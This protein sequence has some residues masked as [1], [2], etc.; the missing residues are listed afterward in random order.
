M[1]KKET[2]TNN[3]KYSVRGAEINGSS[4]GN[5]DVRNGGGVNSPK[6]KEG[7]IKVV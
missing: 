3:C 6:V 2:E 5:H 1:D 4:Q 7:S